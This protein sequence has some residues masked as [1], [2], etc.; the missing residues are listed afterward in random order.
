M[1]S[2]CKQPRVNAGDHKGISLHRM[3]VGPSVYHRE[4]KRA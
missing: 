4:Q 2:G 1:A 3:Q